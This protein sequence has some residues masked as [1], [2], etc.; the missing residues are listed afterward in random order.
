MLFRYHDP[1]P[2]RFHGI[3][4][5][6]S[7]VYW[8]TVSLVQQ[9]NQLAPTRYRKDQF[10]W[11]GFVRSVDRHDDTFFSS[12]PRKGKLLVT[13]QELAIIAVSQGIGMA[14]N[15]GEATD[16][17]EQIMVRAIVRDD[18]QIEPRP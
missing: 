4:T 3:Y 14:P 1:R 9:I 17:P 7:S 13:D 10:K 5:H 11:N 16:D 6:F 12:L 2:T 15:L 18:E 8:E